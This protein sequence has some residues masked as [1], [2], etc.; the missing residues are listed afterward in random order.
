MVRRSSQ[1]AAIGFLNCEVSSNADFLQLLGAVKK[2]N[3]AEY[4]SSPTRQKRDSGENT[5]DYCI[6]VCRF[7]DIYFRKIDRIC[8]VWYNIQQNRYLLRRANNERSIYKL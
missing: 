3:S 1:K 5:Q 6:S 7:L 8:S 2:S 4:P